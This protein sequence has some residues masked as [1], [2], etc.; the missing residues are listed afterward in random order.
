[1]L[2]DRDM[3]SML[4][5]ILECAETEDLEGCRVSTFDEAGLLTGNRG[6]VVRLADGEEFQ[7]TIVQS[8]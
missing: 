2:D 6:L 5:E 7:L 8:R 4:S 1:M 3:E